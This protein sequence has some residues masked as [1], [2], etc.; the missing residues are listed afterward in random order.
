MPSV[1]KWP[2]YLLQGVPESERRW[3]SRAAAARNTSVA[4]VVRS[5]LCKRYRLVCPQQST[6]YNAEK[7]TGST[8]I[9]LRL[10]PNLNAALKREAARKG[11]NR[12]RIILETIKSHYEKG[13]PS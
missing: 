6:H 12:R 3:L 11:R 9:L 13:E 10:Q 8:T 7:D 4:D 1:G 5:I 2:T